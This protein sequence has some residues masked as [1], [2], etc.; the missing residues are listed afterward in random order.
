MT[1]HVSTGL[2]LALGFLV[3]GTA[4]A[5]NS[6]GNADTPPQIIGAKIVARGPD[7]LR[8]ELVTDECTYVSS[9]RQGVKYIPWIVRDKGIDDSKQ[10]AHVVELGPAEQLDGSAEIVTVLVARSGGI[11]SVTV[12]MYVENIKIKEWKAE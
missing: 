12:E 3:S 1:R 11:A 2:A 6:C 10:L 5:D 9:V 4:R 8:A 7:S